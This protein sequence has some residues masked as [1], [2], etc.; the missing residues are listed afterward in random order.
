MNEPLVSIIIPVY[1]TPKDLLVTCIQSI[2][3]QN[4]SNVEVILIDDGSTE[5]S[6]IST[7]HEL[8]NNHNLLVFHESNGGVSFARNKGT[9]YASGKYIMYVDSDDILFPES[10]AVGI[11]IAESKGADMVLGCLIKTRTIIDL[12]LKNTNHKLLDITEEKYD[13]LRSVYL[14]QNPLELKSFCTNGCISRGPVARLIKAKIAKQI[15]FPTDI[16]VGEDIIWNMR[17]L[18][19]VNKICLCNDAWYGYV[20]HDNSAIRKYYGN[21]ELIV[22]DYLKCLEEENKDFCNNNID[23]YCN[24]IVMEFYCILRYELMS[25]ECL[26]TKKEKNNYVHSLLKKEPWVLLANKKNR[27]TL[28]LK[29]KLLLVLCKFN[30]WQGV[31]TWLNYKNSIK[32]SN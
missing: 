14:N 12:N 28:S 9:K 26:M 5:L 22:S 6:T 25:E 15:A 21:R 27:K 13:V 29:H 19:V 31:M 16:A 10:I 18:K 8:E 24:N 7:L 32:K 4:Y 1:N 17:L 11:D 2:N 3:Q 20:I 23:I 30:I